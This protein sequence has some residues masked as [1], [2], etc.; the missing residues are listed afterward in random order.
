MGLHRK[1]G[2]LTVLTLI[3]GGLGPSL[4]WG[5]GALFNGRINKNPVVPAEPAPAGSKPG[6]GT[7]FLGTHLSNKMIGP[8]PFD[9]DPIRDAGATEM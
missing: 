3:N 7:Q 5:D 1:A 2:I 4:R 6:A 9:G 8:R